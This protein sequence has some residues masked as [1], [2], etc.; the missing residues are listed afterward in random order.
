MPATATAYFLCASNQ[1]GRKR[2]KPKVTVDWL[3]EP[4]HIRVNQV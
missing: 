2:A 1:Y 3:I 4:S